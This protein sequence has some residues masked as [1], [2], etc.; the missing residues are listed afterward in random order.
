MWIVHWKI[1]GK[2]GHGTPISYVEARDT[3]KEMN[4]KYG[5]GT[6]WMEEES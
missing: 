1:N 6:H 2:C 3:C 5:G 4:E